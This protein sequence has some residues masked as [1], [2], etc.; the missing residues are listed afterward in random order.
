M[1][2]VGDR[3]RFIEN[4][5]MDSTEDEGFKLGE[6]YEITNIIEAECDEDGNPSGD[7][8]EELIQDG[9]TYQITFNGMRR[10]NI[11]PNSFEKVVKKKAKKESDH[12]DNIRDN[13]RFG[14]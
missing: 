14:Y 10:F 9:Y 5:S 6:I 8:P 7:C 12:L 13:F 2:K 1:W 3:V 11:E 4:G